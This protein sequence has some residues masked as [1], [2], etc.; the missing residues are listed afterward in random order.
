MDW[1]KCLEKRHALR[2]SLR[3]LNNLLGVSAQNLESKVQALFDQ[4]PQAFQALP[5]LLA[6]RN[7]Q[8]IILTPKQEQMP[9]SGYLQSPEKICAFLSQS[10]LLEL[11]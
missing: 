2:V 7:A 6:M 9:L 11:F 8:E 3:V 5:L 10:G 4:N 1:Q